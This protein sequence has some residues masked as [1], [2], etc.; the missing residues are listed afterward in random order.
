MQKVRKA[1]SSCSSERT[2]PGGSIHMDY[3]FF[4]LKKKKKKTQTTARGESASSNVKGYSGGREESPGASS[5]GS[6]LASVE[7]EARPLPRT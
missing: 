7:R 4:K 6:P 3:F 1:K 5:P 2:Y